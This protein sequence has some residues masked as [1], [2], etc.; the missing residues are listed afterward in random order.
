MVCVC[1]CTSEPVIGTQKF[2]ARSDFA[3]K[4]SVRNLRINNEPSEKT[5]LAAGQ[6]FKLSIEIVDENE[7]LSKNVTMGEAI[8]LSIQLQRIDQALA[9]QNSGLSEVGKQKNHVRTFQCGLSG[10]EPGEYRVCVIAMKKES[11]S[12]QSY[13]SHSL[14]DFVISCE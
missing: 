3:S 12:Q 14:R 8:V 6:G 2:Q 4:F 10:V 11:A 5:R 1:G 13:T 9:L 7:L